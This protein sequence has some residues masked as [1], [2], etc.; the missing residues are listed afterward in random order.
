[1]LP[2]GGQVR[3][4]AAQ[5]SPSVTESRGT[6]PCLC[7]W[8][9]V[10]RCD[11][12]K[13][14]ERVRYA[15]TPRAAAAGFFFF[16]RGPAVRPGTG[17]L[18]LSCFADRAKRVW[19]CRDVR[20]VPSS[21]PRASKQ[22]L[23]V[24]AAGGCFAPAAIAFAEISAPRTRRPAREGAKKKKKDNEGKWKPVWLWWVAAGRG[25]GISAL[26]AVC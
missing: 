5:T 25:G 20:R 1:M 22:P 7:C 16:L 17:H 12:C 19:Q 13:G 9:G 21:P 24:H 3:H 14:R 6:G 26:R 23:Y 18:R 15:P 8:A 2:T 4:R 11:G 10:A